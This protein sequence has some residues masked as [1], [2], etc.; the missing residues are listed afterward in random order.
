MP[1]TCEQLEEYYKSLITK[2]QEYLLTYQ[3]GIEQK[4]FKK[5]KEIKKEIEALIDTLK[6]HFWP[7]EHLE[8][9]DL[10]VQYDFQKKIFEELGIL[11]SLSNGAIG[12]KAINEKEY[13]F[14]TFREIVKMTRENKEVLNLKTEQGFNQLLIVPFGMKLDN[15][16]EK[17]KDLLWKH[18]KGKKLFR[19]MKRKGGTPVF[20]DDLPFDQ[21]TIDK[22][23]SGE[24]KYEEIWKETG[25]VY[26]G[27]NS[28]IWVWHQYLNADKTGVLVY[29]PKE[30]SSNHQ[31]RTKQKILKEQGNITGAG[32]NI[33]F[34]E[35][36]PNIP[37]ENP[38]TKGGRTQ[39][40]TQ[41][42]TIKKYIE[43]PGKDI[44][45]PSEYLQAINTEPM[46]AH[47]IG[48][49]PEDQLIY[50]MLYLTKHNQVI[51]D[52][53]GEGNVSYQIGAH[54]PNSLGLQSVCWLRGNCRANLGASASRGRI[55]DAGVRTAVKVNHK[56]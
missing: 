45:S 25:E 18:Y 3:E 5:A 54:F 10:Q 36:M 28:A 30:F 42:S 43:K 19:T 55:S 48:M 33:L 34:I 11:E 51:D 38:E 7:F 39:L 17:Y 44:P 2:K 14:P 49:T 29:Y 50:A 32:F 31:S 52:Y 13:V 1:F 16:I 41:G 6:K 23:K 15:L 20:P 53:G 26:K 46:Y 9:K 22:I 24:I 40:D 12:I 35:D 27:E 56:I 21:D 47:E 37:R 8:K 4:D